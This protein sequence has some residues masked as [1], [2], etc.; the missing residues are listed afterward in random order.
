MKRL[1]IVCV[2]VLAVALCSS[3]FAKG[4]SHGKM[5]P[6]ERVAHMTRI[7]N[8]TPDQQV[9]VKDII[10][11]RDAEMKPLFASLFKATDKEEQREIKIDILEQHQRYRDELN[12]VL[13]DKQAKTYREY[14]KSRKMKH[15]IKK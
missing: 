9:K 6:D 11:R 12:S 15:K 4:Y 7:L 13:T 5:T 10:V 1:L 3:A 14:I 2:A 8:L